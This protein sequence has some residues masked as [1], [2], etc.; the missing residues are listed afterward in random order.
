MIMGI[1]SI[2]ERIQNLSVKD[3]EKLLQEAAAKAEE[4]LSRVK[5]DT[6][7]E[8]ERAAAQKKV[9]LLQRM[10]RNLAEVRIRLRLQQLRE[11]EE[12]LQS[13][14]REGIHKILHLEPDALGAILR[15]LFQR[16]LREVP[17][18]EARVAPEAAPLFSS[19]S[20]L[21]IVSDPRTPMGLLVSSESGELEVDLTFPALEEELWERARLQISELLFG[22]SDG[23]PC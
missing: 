7:R 19:E 1:E 22:G 23:S 16:A 14:R 8:I 12:I 15:H 6:R 21:K 9:Q 13:V 2:L 4:L 3:C 17:S 11:R 18:G 20:G 5:E 10:E